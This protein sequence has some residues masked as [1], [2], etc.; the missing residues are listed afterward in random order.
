MGWICKTWL[1][2]IRLLVFDLSYFPIQKELKILSSNSSSIVFP[3]MA[4]RWFIA[5]L[6]SIATNSSDSCFSSETRVFSNEEEA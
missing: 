3:K 2:V 5:I 6:R 1:I 4:A